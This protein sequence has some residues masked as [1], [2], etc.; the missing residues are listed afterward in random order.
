MNVG[1]PVIGEVFQVFVDVPI[2][3]EFGL[4]ELEHAMLFAA[5]VFKKTTRICGDVNLTVPLYPNQDRWQLMGYLFSSDPDDVGTLI[6]YGTNSCWNCTASTSQLA[7][8]SFRALCFDVPQGHR[9]VL[10]VDMFS[11]MFEPA[12]KNP[13]LK[14]NFNFNASAVLHVDV[15]NS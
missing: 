12:N 7:V 2:L 8:F 5:P 9:L 11:E 13:A 14:I 6:S 15:M 4:V 10:G 3:C 1:F